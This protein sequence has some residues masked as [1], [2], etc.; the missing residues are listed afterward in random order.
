MA[1]IVFAGTPIFAATVLNGLIEDR[2][3]GIVAVY[4][5]PDR[6]AGRGLRF[7]ETS[8]KM[9]ARAAGL[10]VRDPVSLKTPSEQEALARLAPDLMVVVGYGQILPQTVL[11]IPVLGCINVHAS[12]LPRWRGAA[13]IAAAILAGDTESGVTI[14]R[15]TAGLD[16]GPILHQIRCPITDGDTAG[17]LH[18]RLADL[19]KR[20]LAEALAAVFAGHLEERPQDQRLATYAPKVE[21]AQARLDWRWPAAELARRVRAFNPRPVAFGEVAGI[22]LRV[23]EAMAVHTPTERP[24]GSVWASG[25]GLDVATSAGVLRL[26]RVQAP[27]R[28]P[29]SAAEFLRGH[30]EITRA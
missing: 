4:T 22:E 10:Q 7:A 26:L 23:F 19:G 14:M 3:A 2:G 13:P 17:D 1:R 6:P 16:T 12:L 18:D 5:Q 30:P 11:D 29:L 15:M 20:A 9:L 21:R 24:P 25:A 8:V 27:G 28:R